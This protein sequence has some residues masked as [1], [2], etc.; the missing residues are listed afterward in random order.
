[1]KALVYT[2]DVPDFAV[3]AQCH[4]KIFKNLPIE[5][6]LSDVIDSNLNH[7]ITYK[8]TLTQTNP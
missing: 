7:F 3:V 8:L 1:M 2:G 6:A 4:S 5:T